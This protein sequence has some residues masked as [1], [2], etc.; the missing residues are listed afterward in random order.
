MNASPVQLLYTRTH[1]PAARTLLAP[2]GITDIPERIKIKK[3]KQKFYYDRH[4]HEL[5]KLAGSDAIRM[6]LP[7]EHEWS[8]GHVIGDEG[9]RAANNGRSTDNVQS[10][11]GIDWT[12]P[13][14]AG[15]L[16]RSFTDSF[17]E[18]AGQRTMSS[19]HWVLTGQILGLPDILSA[20]L[21]TPSEKFLFLTV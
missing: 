14:I 16:V 6:R 20:P 12:N 9:N 4:S 13:W 11:L 1:L 7:G 15:H 8:L 17:R 3:E 2:D 18:M 10:T 21:L 19:Q 5:P